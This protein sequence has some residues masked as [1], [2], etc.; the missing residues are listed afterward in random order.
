M[1]SWPWLMPSQMSVAKYR[2]D[3]APFWSAAP[4]GG[5]GQL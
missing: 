1:P 2:A 5:L 4:G 3:L